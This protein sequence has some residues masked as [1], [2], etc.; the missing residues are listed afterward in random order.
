MPY[1][2]AVRAEDSA[3]PSHEDTNSVTL[4]AVPGTNGA[5]SNFRKITIDGDFSNWVGLPWAY[6]GAPDGNP[7]NFIKVQ[8]ANDEN[9]LYGHFVLAS[10]AAPFS[11]INTHLFVD[12]DNNA[13]TGFQASSAAFGSEW[14]IEGSAGYDERNGG[15][16][17]GVISGLGWALAPARRQGI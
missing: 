3:S 15:F 17:E 8:F 1:F 6:Q 5:A 7:V 11:D 12:G 4:L 9:Y 16:N 13:Q 2:V 14:M 10:N